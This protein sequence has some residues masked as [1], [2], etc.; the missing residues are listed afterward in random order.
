M[1]NS[2]IRLSPLRHTWILDLDG[3]LVVHNGY[4]NGKD[5]FL[6]GALEFL[7]SIPSNDK[8]IILTA[9][10]AEAKEL[11]ESFLRVNN[12]KYDEIIFEVPMGERVLIN[13]TKP[14]GL[15]CAYAITPQRNTGF[16]QEIFCIDKSK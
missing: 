14:S 13:D 10:E 8:V 3:T 1:N 15:V 16:P 5:E 2:K 11:T 9:R 12:V 4:K 6:P 7:H